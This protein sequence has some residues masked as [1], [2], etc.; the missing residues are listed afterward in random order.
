MITLCLYINCYEVKQNQRWFIL[1][2]VTAKE[3]EFFYLSHLSYFFIYG[4]KNASG[5]GI[6][7]SVVD[8][9]NE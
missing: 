7:Y 2:E 5:I 8:D 9:S 3:H 1:H 4:L 6:N